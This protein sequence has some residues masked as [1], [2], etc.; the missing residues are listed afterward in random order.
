MPPALLDSTC[1]AALPLRTRLTGAVGVL[2]LG[3]A[4]LGA[5][6]AQAFQQPREVQLYSHDY[7]NASVP[8]NGPSRG[9]VM[10]QDRRLNRVIAFESDASNLVSGDTNGST[11]VFFTT[12]SGSYGSR[13][14]RYQ[15]GSVQLASRGRGGQPANGRS[16]GAAVGGVGARAPKCV[17]FVSEASNLVRGDTNKRADAFVYWISSRKIQRVST[18]SRNRQARGSSTSITVDGDCTKV[19]FTSDA[20]NLALTRGGRSEWRQARSRT[21]KRGTTQVYMKFIRPTAKT[22][23]EFKNL[24]MVISRRGSHPGNR[25]S[26]QPH[27]V[28]MWGRTVVYSS[29]ASNLVRSD[30]NGSS[31]VFAFEWAPKW[32]RGQRNLL[33]KTKA[34]SGTS[35]SRTAN[36]ASQNP[37]IAPFAGSVVYETTASDLV[38]NGSEPKAVRTDLRTYR[39]YHVGARR[40]GG[41][42]APSVTG[43]SKWVF[44]EAKGAGGLPETWLWFENRQDRSQQIGVPAANPTTSTHGNYLTVESPVRPQY[45][46]NGSRTNGLAS[47][48]TGT[49][50]SQPGQLWL[51][52]TDEQ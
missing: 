49:S 30:S 14:S 50:L 37:E 17:A 23:R 28:A 27:M 29:D 44:Y 2:A 39:D 11:D 45:V 32:S 41:T 5:A 26:S 34:V 47:G 24:T 25:N 6:D 20:D 21:P 4:T 52:W 22:E 12:R 3:V 48:L 43:Q 18:D 10:S 46:K 31:D 42:R 8:G 40:T 19:A 35:S 13:G 7:R 15:P 1:L 38:G 51:I 33:H 9:A 16:W 36:G